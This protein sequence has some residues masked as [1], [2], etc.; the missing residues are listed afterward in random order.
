MGRNHGRQSSSAKRALT[1]ALMA[2]MLVGTGCTGEGG[3]DGGIVGMI[4]N[5]IG[6]I[7]S[8]SSSA[9][10]G[11]SAA[12]GFTNPGASTGSMVPVSPGSTSAPTF[13]SPTF[14]EPGFTSPT[15]DASSGGVVAPAGGG[16]VTAPVTTADNGS[17]GGSGIN[18]G[19]AWDA[20]T[21]FVGD[22]WNSGVQTATNIGSTVGG[23]FT[24][25]DGGSTGG[26]G[27]YDPGTIN[28]D[29]GSSGGGE[30]PAL[31]PVESAGNT[32]NSVVINEG[33]SGPYV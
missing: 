13:T 21:G 33:I 12:T 24:P 2:A 19:G 9:P 1:G 7:G 14:T 30:L 22:M 5:L 29:P 8:M 17:S 18:W 31:P 10:T 16:D 28:I 11:P 6:A 23:W 27:T 15:F 4:I 3:A 25:S 32:D 26:A 20:T